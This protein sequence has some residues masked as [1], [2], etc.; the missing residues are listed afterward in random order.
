MTRQEIADILKKAA[1]G[2]LVHYKNGVTVELGLNT[3]GK[4]RA[5]LVAISWKKI[6]TIVEVKSGIEDFRTDKKLHNYRKYCHKM[7]VLFPHNTYLQYKQEIINKIGS[8]IG[9]LV[10]DKETGL[11]KV[12]KRSTSL[13]VDAE[14]VDSILLKMAW[15]SGNNC[16]NTYRY[17][18]FLES[19]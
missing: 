17:R 5:D 14:T 6:I 11:C 19:I 12:V 13:E 18:Y 10:L 2:W 1:V 3:S 15:R 7:Y 9:I 16:S 8:D 4:W